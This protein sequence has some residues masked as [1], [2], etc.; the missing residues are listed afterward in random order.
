MMRVQR[1]GRPFPKTTML[2]MSEPYFPIDE[3]RAAGDFA[4]GYGCL[5]C[6][7]VIAEDG[8]D[9]CEI[10]VSARGGYATFTAHAGCLR[11]AAH[12]SDHL[13]D[14]ETP[15][16]PPPDYEPPSQEFLDAWDDLSEVL[17]QIHHAELENAADVR[18]LMRAVQAA[19]TQ[20]GV[21]IELEE[22]D[23]EN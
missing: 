18:S 3:E 23:A 7:E 17:A 19:A 16:E 22:E 10:N 1:R 9:F 20:H 14:I 21:E 2:R 12:D 6:G 4:I 11:T 15:A 8:P 13:P 5:F